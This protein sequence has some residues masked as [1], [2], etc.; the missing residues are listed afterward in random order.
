MQCVAIL[1]YVEKR[2]K[3][4][5]AKKSAG[6]DIDPLDRLEKMIYNLQESETFYILCGIISTKVNEVT[7]GNK[8]HKS[9]WRSKMDTI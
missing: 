1:L 8:H 6:I 5:H 9:E 4:Y 7:Y 3:S 2:E